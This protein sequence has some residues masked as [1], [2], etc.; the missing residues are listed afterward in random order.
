MR[1]GSGLNWAGQKLSGSGYNLKI[2]WCLGRDQRKS[3]EELQG[4]GVEEVK[5]WNCHSLKWGNWR[6]SRFG[7]EKKSGLG[8]TAL[9]LRCQLDIPYS[10]R[11]C[12]FMSLEFGGESQ[13]GSLNLR[14]VST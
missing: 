2:C 14:V 10:S 11:I 13:V 9:S 6:K 12:G 1:T 4:L 7:A 5:E 8:F 3:Q